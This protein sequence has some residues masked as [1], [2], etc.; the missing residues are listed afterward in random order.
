MLARVPKVRRL[1]CGDLGHTLQG[2]D[3]PGSSVSIVPVRTVFHMSTFMSQRHRIRQL[4][5]STQYLARAAQ[6]TPEEEVRELLA[7][8]ATTLIHARPALYP[9]LLGHIQHQIMLNII[10]KPKFY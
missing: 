8:G 7:G 4:E 10:F 1:S 9:P 6:H 3:C 2:T 5:A